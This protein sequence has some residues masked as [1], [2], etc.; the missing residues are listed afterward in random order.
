MIFLLEWD[1][2]FKNVETGQTEEVNTVKLLVLSDSHSML[3]FMRR[4]I[5]RILPDGVIHLGDYFEDGEAMKEEFPGIPFYQVPGNCDLYRCQPGQ[6]EIL[7]ESF[8]G[9]TLYLTHGHRHKV[10]MYLAALLRDARKCHGAAA[11][12][13]HTHVADC[14]QEED[15]LWVLN[16]GSCGYYGGSAGLME[17]QKGKILSCRIL[18]EDDL[19][20][21]FPEL[22]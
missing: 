17:I 13:G 21:E 2:M 3:S 5:G 12:Y 1:M 6:P 9:V 4:C 19:D 16:P 18:R 15:G 14:H 8:D 20:R 22:A 11:L 10:K 7:V